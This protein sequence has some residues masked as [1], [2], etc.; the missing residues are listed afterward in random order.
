MNGKP[1]S[2]NLVSIDQSLS[3]TGI[4]FYLHGE[5]EIFLEKTKKTKDPIP[6]PVCGN[7]LKDPRSA[8]HRGS[9]AHQEA[10]QELGAEKEEELMDLLREGGS[11]HC[12]ENSLRIQYI[13]DRIYTL[14]KDRKIKYGIIEGMAFGASVRGNFDK[15]GLFYA[16]ADA[17]NRLKIKF[18]VIPP[19]VAKRYWT[20]SGNAGKS[21]MV[22]ESKRRGIEIPFDYNDDCNDAFVFLVF[23]Q[24]LLSGT[25]TEEF[26]KKVEFSWK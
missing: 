4:A 5:Y 17:F 22:E 18:V 12:I 16:I 25:L 3:S 1:K 11:S 26:T 2:L 21:D 8:G 19:T 14:C 6:C 7:V 13:R 20:G 9:K 10:I 15:G 23:L 24:E